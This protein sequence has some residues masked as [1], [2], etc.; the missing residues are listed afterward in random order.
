MV[1]EN[2]AA[3][4]AGINAKRIFHTSNCSGYQYKELI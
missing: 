2:S 1:D 4:K 3:G